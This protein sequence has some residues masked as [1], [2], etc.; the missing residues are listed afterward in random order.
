M[1]SESSI[2]DSGKFRVVPFERPRTRGR[3][4]TYY[5][6]LLVIPE[7]SRGVSIFNQFF[8]RFW[9]KQRRSCRPW[10]V[11]KIHTNVYNLETAS[12]KP[13]EFLK[14]VISFVTTIKYCHLV[15]IWKKLRWKSHVLAHFKS[16]IEIRKKIKSLYGLGGPCPNITDV[17]INFN[18][19]SRSITWLGDISQPY[20]IYIC[21]IFLTNIANMKNFYAGILQVQ[22]NS[23]VKLKGEYQG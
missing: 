17:C 5:H 6:P 21:G 10:N 13:Y 2:N 3:P 1:L 15:T 22:E 8:L 14:R 20:N 23:L 16:I 7:L 18:H 11:V 9:G 19:V 4:L 12:P